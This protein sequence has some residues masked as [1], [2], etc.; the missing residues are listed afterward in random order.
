[1]RLCALWDQQPHIDNEAIPSVIALIDNDKVI[2]ALADAA[3]TPYANV[4][5]VDHQRPYGAR[6]RRARTPLNLI[7]L[8]V[9]KKGDFGVFFL[10]ARRREPCAGHMQMPKIAVMRVAVQEPVEPINRNTY[11]ATLLIW[12]NAP[13]RSTK[14]AAAISKNGPPSL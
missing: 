12:I 3:R 1:L 5:I 7:R 4:T 13:P 14:Y 2:G 11:T 10:D 9:G 6:R 8:N